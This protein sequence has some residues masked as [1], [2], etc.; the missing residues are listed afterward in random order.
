MTEAAGLV[1]WTL[2]ITVA[3][4]EP[5]HLLHPWPSLAVCEARG[6]AARRVWQVWGREVEWVCV[7]EELR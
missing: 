2:Y 7:E 5:I 4:P 3:T 6:E 1:I